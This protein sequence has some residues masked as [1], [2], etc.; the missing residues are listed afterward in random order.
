MRDRVHPYSLMVTSTSTP[1][2]MEMEVICFTT[3]AGECRS[4][5]RLWMRIWN[6]SHVFVPGGGCGGHE[7]RA[8]AQGAGREQRG[9]P[10]GRR[11]GRGRGR[12]GRTLPA[13]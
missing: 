10:A 7:R 2:S 11:E 1:G 12:L 13:G 3:S 9:R 5:M 8:A 6:R 4:M